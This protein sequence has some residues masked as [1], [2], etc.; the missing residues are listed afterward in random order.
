MSGVMDSLTMRRRAYVAALSAVGVAGC[1][2]LQNLMRPEAAVQ[3]VINDWLIAIENGDEDSVVGLLHPE[4]PDG[5]SL[6]LGLLG[7]IGTD[8]YI[9]ELDIQVNGTEARAESTIRIPDLEETDPVYFDISDGRITEELVLRKTDSGWQIWQHFFPQPPKR[10]EIKL[11]NRQ[12]SVEV[13]ESA[14]MI[15]GQPDFDEAEL[16]EP[17]EIPTEEQPT[18]YSVEGGF[19]IENI[20]ERRLLKLRFLPV[21]RTKS[22]EEIP[23]S[24]VTN[25]S[26]PRDP[27]IDRLESGESREVRIKTEVPAAVGR[28]DEIRI[29]TMFQ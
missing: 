29:E 16:G 7:L 10:S 18:L 5:V 9:E 14:E 6:I 11:V 28:P 17:P 3:T 23:V 26:N 12:L 8:I 13:A 24:K 2:Q 25:M 15:T 1:G 20:S 19:K 21:L 27:R 4:S 22:S